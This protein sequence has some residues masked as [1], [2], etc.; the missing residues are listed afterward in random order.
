MSC[1][2]S[3]K[4]TGACRLGLF[5]A[6]QRW[7]TCPAR[8]GYGCSATAR[9]TE[10]GHDPVETFMHTVIADRH[11]LL[12]GVGFM[13]FPHSIQPYPHPLVVVVCVCDPPGLLSGVRC[14]CFCCCLVAG[15]FCCCCCCLSAGVFCCCCLACSLAADFCC[16]CCLGVAAAAATA[17]FFAAAA[18]STSAAA[19]L[20]FLASCRNDTRPAPEHKINTD[21]LA[22]NL[23]NY[24]MSAPTPQLQPTPE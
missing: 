22:T 17:C 18:P 20:R 16:C 8:T 9:P 6:R 3:H 15:V 10:T 21:N 5:D 12:L 7:T 19:A 11:Q 4:I 13:V 1:E 2:C 14:S 23:T 24:T